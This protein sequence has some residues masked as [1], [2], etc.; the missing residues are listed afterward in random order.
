MNR[1]KITETCR[2]KSNISSNTQYGMLAEIIFEK[3]LPG[4]NELTCMM[5]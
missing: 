3:Y 5:K 2:N 1:Q 4:N